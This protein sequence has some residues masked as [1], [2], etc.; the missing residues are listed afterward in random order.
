MHKKLFNTENT[1]LVI[2]K[3]TIKVPQLSREMLLASMYMGRCMIEQTKGEK[4]LLE[5]KKKH[6]LL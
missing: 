5:E 3:Q 1:Y 4:T 6:F 2:K